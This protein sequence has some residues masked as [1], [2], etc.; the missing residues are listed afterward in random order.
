[1]KLNHS[2]LFFVSLIFMVSSCN[3]NHDSS[4]FTEGP[5]IAS[6]S[7]TEGG[8]ASGPF[9]DKDILPLVEKHCKS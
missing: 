5:V 7:K 2:Y 1:M 6:C 9:Y 3:F 8:E 4:N